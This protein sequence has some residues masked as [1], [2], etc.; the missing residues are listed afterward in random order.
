MEWEKVVDLG[1]NLWA[2]LMDS[3]PNIDNTIDSFVE[4]GDELACHVFIFGRQ[5]KDFAGIPS[6]NLR[7]EN[8]HIFVFRFDE[9]DY[10]ASIIVSWDHERFCEQLGAK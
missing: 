4:N 2:A 3:F 8:D 7:F 10:I 5:E 6:K 9:D 1:K